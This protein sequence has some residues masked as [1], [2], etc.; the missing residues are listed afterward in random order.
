[1]QFKSFCKFSTPHY[2][3]N[4]IEFVINKLQE[5]DFAY[6]QIYSK[7]YL[8]E[9]DVYKKEKIYYKFTNDDNTVDLLLDI[10][11]T[12]VSKDTYDLAC[13]IRDFLSHIN[14]YQSGKFD[15]GLGEI[16]IFIC[17]IAWCDHNLM[18]IDL[19]FEGIDDKNEYHDYLRSFTQAVFE[20]CGFVSDDITSKNL[21]DTYREY[22]MV[23]Y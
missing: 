2:T 4:R 16:N 17:D 8:M 13:S 23:A 9:N 12:G 3:W 10:L 19:N 15:R 14:Y 11:K 5:L 20:F 1:M 21:E 6:N 22:G 18:E 7:D